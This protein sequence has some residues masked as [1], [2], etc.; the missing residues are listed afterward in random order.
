[1]SASAHNEAEAPL[2]WEQRLS[3][4]LARRGWIAAAFC[5]VVAAIATLPL[6]TSGFPRGNDAIKHYRWSTEFATALKDGSLY[7][8]WFPEANH[9]EGSP[10]PIYYPPV[11]FYVS[12]AFNVVVGN[13]L[14]AISLSCWFALAL[15]G[16]TMY[17]LSRLALS[18]PASLVAAAL[19]MLIPYHMLD[20]Y[21]G[22]AISEFW[23]FAWVPLI[24]YFVY[25]VGEQDGWLALGGLALGYALLLQTHVPSAFLT[26]LALPI[27]ALSL[28]RDYKR[29]FR[30]AAGLA[31][32]AGLSAIFVVPILFERKYIQIG[33]VVLRR[34]YRN[35]FLFEQLGPAFKTILIP[36]EGIDYSLQA[37]LAAFGL[38]LFLAVAAALMWRERR[39]GGPN[40]PGK[41]WLAS[42]IITAITLLMTARLTAPLYRVVPGLVFLLFPFRW[43]LVCSAGATFLAAAS[44]SLVTNDARRRKPYAAA[45]VIVAAF[46]LT[47]SALAVA[48]MPQD[49]EGLEKRRTRREAPEYHPVWW[50]GDQNQALKETPAVVDSGDAV[51][52]PIDEKGVKQSYDVSAS[53]ESVVRLRPLYFPGWVARVDDKPVAIWPSADGNIELKIEPGEHR[54]TLS[55]EDTWPRRAGKLLSAASLLCLLAWVFIARRMKRRLKSA[56][57]LGSSSSMT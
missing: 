40:L 53:S 35:Y 8:R 3:I 22:S 4:R 47:V 37:D 5:C 10:L 57:H 49:A 14:T 25:R 50:G 27:F 48:R 45:L 21:L 12:A 43:L 41:L 18:R 15:S 19:Y 33:R 17:G 36:S 38:L 9:G 30:V 24:F 52:Q 16:L 56:V 1:M 31:L 23:S 13:M 20:L 2:N 32:G 7:P 26:S 51:I 11:P 39:A 54:L 42:L 55:F 29:L 6:F 46:N 28:T 34:D 44:V